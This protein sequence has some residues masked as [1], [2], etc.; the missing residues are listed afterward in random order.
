MSDMYMPIKLGAT[1][2]F[3]QPDALKVLLYLC[4]YVCS[5]IIPYNYMFK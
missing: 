2:H 1:V 4:V 3:T 5:C